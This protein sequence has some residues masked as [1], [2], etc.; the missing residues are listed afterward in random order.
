[1]RSL[2]GGSSF[3][4]ASSRLLMATR[5]KRGTA[6]SSNR[7]YPRARRWERLSGP[8]SRE[9]RIS[10]AAAYS[11]QSRSADLFRISEKALLDPAAAKHQ[12]AAIKHRGLPRRNC[13]LRFIEED[14]HAFARPGW[15]ERSGSGF[16][17]VADFDLGPRRR[18]KPWD[19]DPI[20]A[21][22][23]KAILKQLASAAHRYALRAGIGRD[24]VKRLRGGN[25]KPAPLPDGKA[26][27]T[28]VRAERLSC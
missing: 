7:A 23:G 9:A 3:G 2:A 26:M 11:T 18:G 22:R 8:Y 25:A 4:K 12:I 6:T 14:L 24:H 27:R 13:P 15:A 16:V 20:D 5:R 17:L 28:L 1:M 19:R 21:G 10:R